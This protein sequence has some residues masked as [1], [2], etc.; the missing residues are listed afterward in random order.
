MGS[1]NISYYIEL[2]IFPI[3]DHEQ[4]PS[5]QIIQNT[6]AC[7]SCHPGRERCLRFIVSACV[8]PYGKECIVHALHSFLARQSGP[9]QD[10]LND[11][12]VF[13]DEVFQRTLILLLQQVYIVF[14][15]DNQTVPPL[16]IV[17]VSCATRLLS[18]DELLISIYFRFSSRFYHKAQ[19][20]F[21]S[22]KAVRTSP[23]V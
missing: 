23:I 22:K 16:V 6:V 14:I 1:Y 13:V 11:P 5:F 19:K 4:V 20:Y 18:E 3:I 7:D 10:R 8:L 17:R 15:C 2:Q 21:Q 9:G 12:S